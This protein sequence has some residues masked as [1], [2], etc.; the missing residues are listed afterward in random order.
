MYHR[1]L[2]SAIDSFSKFNEKNC[3]FLTKLGFIYKYLPS[4]DNHLFIFD[5]QF[6][7]VHPYQFYANPILKKSKSIQA[8]AKISNQN[9]QNVL[10]FVYACSCE[11]TCKIR[12]TRIHDWSSYLSKSAPPLAFSP[13]LR[14]NYFRLTNILLY[15]NL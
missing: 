14:P 3:Y 13:V 2:Y 5:I 7:P 10:V 4:L 1:I 6:P 11:F 8:V 15:Y 12:L 9:Q